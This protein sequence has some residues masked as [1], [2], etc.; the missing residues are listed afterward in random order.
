MRV[1]AIVLLA[2]PGLAAVLLAFLP[3][4]SAYADP[5]ATVVVDATDV[6]CAT[7][8]ACVQFTTEAIAAYRLGEDGKA[9]DSRV[10]CAATAPG[11]TTVTIRCSVQ[12]VMAPEQTANG[13]VASTRA[14]LD[15]YQEYTLTVCYSATAVFAADQSTVTTPT[16]CSDL[17]YTIG[18]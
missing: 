16:L 2:A 12:D 8:T 7:P 5:Q 4:T 1:R 9:Y 17:W 6:Y 18:M 10:G 11:A 14:Y 3:A 15:L 13:P